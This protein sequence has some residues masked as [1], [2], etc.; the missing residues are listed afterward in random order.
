MKKEI[1][2]DKKE[3]NKLIDENNLYKKKNIELKENL[4]KMEKERKSIL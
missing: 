2:K 4:E 1:G 3:I